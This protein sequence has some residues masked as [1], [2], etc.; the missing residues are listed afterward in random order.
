M[1]ES[2]EEIRIKWIKEKPHYLKL[3]DLL[4]AE[5]KKTLKSIG[6]SATVTSRPKEVESLVRKVIKQQAEGRSPTFDSIVDKI[7]LRAVVRFDEEVDEAVEVLRRTFNCIKSEYKSE[8]RDDNVSDLEHKESLKKFGYRSCHMDITLA[9][10]HPSYSTFGNIPAELQI[11]THAQDLWAVMAHELSY[12]SVLRD[13]AIQRQEAIDR[14]VYILSAIIEAA[15]M[16][17]AR[18]NKE[19]VNTLGAELLILLRA[20]EREYFKFTGQ[21]YDREFSLQCLKFLSAI[22]PR[23]VHQA[24]VALAEFSGKHNAKLSHIFSDQADNPDRSA[25][26]FQPEAIF[27][28][29]C[30]E[31][32]QLV[33]EEEWEKHY[34]AREL[35]RLATAWGVPVYE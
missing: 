7:G 1:P 3:C 20:L 21:Q 15:D 9:Q 31:N 6:I 34:P 10:G 18:M 23:P 13:V 25:F 4:D 11:R 24:K 26:L 29:E 22:N 33:L 8:V 30:L 19:I 35:E 2:V 27:I 16:E 5:L 14:R 32:Q 17:F 12:K 28:F